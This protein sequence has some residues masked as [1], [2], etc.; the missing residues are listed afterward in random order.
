[1][2]TFYACGDFVKCMKC[3]HVLT[4][5]VT[6]GNGTGSGLVLVGTGTMLAATGRYHEKDTGTGTEE[7]SRAK[8]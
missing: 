7:H 2:E 8:L 5:K 4:W 3:G 1:V 6:S